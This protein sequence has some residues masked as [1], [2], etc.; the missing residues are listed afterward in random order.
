MANKNNI[1]S[2]HYLQIIKLLME[3]F[4]LAFFKKNPQPLKKGIHLDLFTYLEQTDNEM[5]KTL[6]KRELRITL[7][8]YSHSM[9]YLLAQRAGTAR[10]D[11]AGNNVSEVTKEE[12]RY[13]NGV[14][15]A[16]RKKQ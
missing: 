5:L 1:T 3:Q 7:Q 15:Q 2:K 16:R 4:P 11:L 6:S 12:E 13:V 8:Y 14:I 9:D 10:I